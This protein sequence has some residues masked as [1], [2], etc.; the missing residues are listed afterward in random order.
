MVGPALFRNLTLPR[1]P[2]GFAHSHLP[3]LVREECRDLLEHIHEK[4]A[5]IEA[6]TKALAGPAKQSDT[7]SRLQTMPSVGPLGALAVEAFAP[8]MQNFRRERDFA[9]WLALVDQS[10]Q[11][12]FQ[13]QLT[14]RLCPGLS[15]L[16]R[17]PVCCAFM[18]IR[19]RHWA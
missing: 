2:P 12:L 1:R 17:F 3:D 15:D 11:V 10:Y 18:P 9:A 4:S 14:T 19:V 6:K 13:F 5:R 8:V 16:E 7:A